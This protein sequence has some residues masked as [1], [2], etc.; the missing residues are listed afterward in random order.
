MLYLLCSPSGLCSRP[1]SPCAAPSY[2]NP[3]VD[4][5][6]PDPGV[7]YDAPSST[8][9]AYGTNGNGKNIQ[10]ATSKDFCSWQL[11]DHDALPPPY[12][13]WTGKPGF[14]WAPEVVTAPGNR[15][16]YLMYVS[17]ADS[18]TDKQAIGVAYSEKSPMGPFHF[19][20]NG[21]IV[22]RVS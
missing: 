8:W 12:P 2:A 13:Q 1:P 16:G 20:S 18:K 10:V 3:V 5:D 9:Y 14:F 6:F 11:H 21:P 4:T 22:S 19:V 17:C 7:F 15:G